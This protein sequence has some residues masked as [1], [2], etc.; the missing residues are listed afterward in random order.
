MGRRGLS[1]NITLDR[2]IN[3][4][5]ERQILVE[6]IPNRGSSRRIPQIRMFLMF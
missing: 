3:A 6:M 2:D 5:M 4:V 1:L